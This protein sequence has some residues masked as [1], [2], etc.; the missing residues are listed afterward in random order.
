MANWNI[1][2]KNGENVKFDDNSVRCNTEYR[3]A[4]NQRNNG[5]NFFEQSYTTNRVVVDGVPIYEDQ[6]IGNEQSSVINIY[7][8][9][10]N[11]N[12]NDPNGQKAFNKL[13]IFWFFFI[14]PMFFVWLLL[15]IC[16]FFK[17]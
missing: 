5:N 6:G 7:R 17:E 8:E 9:M 12:S 4:D 1:K 11:T 3:D 15:K 10:Q 13:M 2:K 14:P 16:G